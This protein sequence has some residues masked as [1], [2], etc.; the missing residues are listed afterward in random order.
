MAAHQPCRAN[1][2]VSLAPEVMVTNASTTQAVQETKTIPIVI[3]Q[4]GDP[5]ANGLVRNIARPDGNI[6]GFSN[7][8]PA[9]AGKWLALLKRLRPA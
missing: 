9:T 8:E 5:V 3:A 1:E 6:T 7:L 4:G 2:L